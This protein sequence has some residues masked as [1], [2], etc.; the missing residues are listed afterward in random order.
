MLACFV[1]VGY[2]FFFVVKNGFCALFCIQKC[3]KMADFCGF[4]RVLKGLL[5][6]IMCFVILFE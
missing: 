1:G 2:R 3:E 5:N 4:W 6:M